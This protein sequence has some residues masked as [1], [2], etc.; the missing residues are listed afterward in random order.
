MFR[1]IYHWNLPNCS[2]LV[3]KDTATAGQ[4]ADGVI[5][6]LLQETHTSFLPHLQQENVS[7]TTR[8]TVRRRNVKVRQTYLCRNEKN[9]TTGKKNP[10]NLQSNGN[11]VFRK[12]STSVFP[13]VTGP[14]QTVRN[15]HANGCNSKGK[16]SSGS[17][18]GG[19]EGEKQEDGT[20]L[21]MQSKTQ[22]KFLITAKFVPMAWVGIL[23][24]WQRNA[25]VLLGFL[26]VLS[27]GICLLIKV[28]NIKREGKMHKDVEN[29]TTP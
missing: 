8:C 27:C 28:Y 7:I 13:V 5:R 2:C 25:R 19:Q 6:S 9:V 22:E 20:P 12:Q 14:K 1:S 26:L 15:D 17:T 11:Y 24:V 21:G 23:S 10:G 4:A 29:T 3:A 18:T 16:H